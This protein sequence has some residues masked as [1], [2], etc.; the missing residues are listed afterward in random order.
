MKFKPGSI[1]KCTYCLLPCIIKYI[2]KNNYLVI[3]DF[4]GG[5]LYNTRCTGDG[6][7]DLLKLSTI[8]ELLEI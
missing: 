6:R 3:K 2:D 4:S 7:N 1:Y 8:E 5:N